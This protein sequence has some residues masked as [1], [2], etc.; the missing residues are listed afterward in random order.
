MTDHAEPCG[1]STCHEKNILREP[2]L[3]IQLSN[4]GQPWVMFR[5]CDLI[6]LQNWLADEAL[7]PDA[8][9]FRHEVWIDRHG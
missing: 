4:P 8:V 7:S 6:C 2:H 1:S 5:F 3:R 9:V